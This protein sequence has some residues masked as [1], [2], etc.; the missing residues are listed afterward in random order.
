MADCWHP[1]V[2]V[3]DN[4]PEVGGSGDPKRHPPCPLTSV[5]Q[6]PLWIHK[7]RS[8]YHTKNRKND[9]QSISCPWSLC[10]APG[11]ITAL[12]GKSS[13]PAQ[14]GTQSFSR[15]PTTRPSTFTLKFQGNQHSY[16]SMSQVSHCLR[17]WFSHTC[18]SSCGSWKPK[19]GK[20]TPGLLLPIGLIPLCLQ[21]F[22]S[23]LL[24]AH[25]LQ[26]WPTI[27]TS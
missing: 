22:C 16:I 20:Q 21:C 3:A 17:A 26:E 1:C 11:S 15:L 2:P 24:E 10:W 9:S 6:N 13:F 8:N 25:A 27:P 18:S 19:P 7:Q 5:K 12:G 23:A 14:T 4:Y